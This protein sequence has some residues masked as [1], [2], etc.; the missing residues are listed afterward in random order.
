MELY[1]P[2]AKALQ[3]LVRDWHAHPETEL[4]ACFGPKGRVD[5]TTFL[6]IATRLKSKGFKPLPQIDRLSVLLPDQVRFQ[7][8]GFGIIQQYCR[9]DRMAGKPFVAMIKD[10]TVGTS[11]NLDLQEYDIR[12]KSRRELPL[13]KE[14]PKIQEL[15]NTWPLQKKAFRLIRRWSFEGAGVVYDLSMIRSSPQDVRGNYRFVRK[16]GDYDLIGSAPIYEV[17]VELKRGVGVGE[18]VGEGVGVGVGASDVALATKTLIAGLTTILRGIQKNILLCRKSVKTS[19]L[20]SYAEVADTDRFRGVAPITMETKNMQSLIDDATPN[21]RTGYNVTEKADGLRV[22][23]LCDKYGELY[24]IDMGMNVYRTG[25]VQPDCKS[26]LLD[27]E[28]VTRTKDNKAIQQLLI[29][30]IYVGPGKEN[31]TKLPFIA[32]TTADSRHKRLENWIALWKEAK[33]LPNTGLTPQTQIQV[34]MKKFVVASAGNDTIFRAAAQVLDTSYI[35]HTDGLIFTPNEAPLPQK[36]GTGFLS[37]FK[38]KPAEDNT[39]DFLVVTEKEP[40]T[41]KMDRI[42]TGIHP[43]SGETVSYKTLRLFVGSSKAAGEND[44]RTTILMEQPIGMVAKGNTYKPVLFNP[45]DNPDTMAT[46]CY[47]PVETDPDSGEQYIRAENSGEIIR[48]RSIVEMAYDPAR[49]PGWRWYAMRVRTDKTERLLKGILARTLNSEDVAESVWNSIHDPVTVSMIRTGSDEP[50]Q[51]EIAS[52]LKT[53]GDRAELSKKYYE[54]KAPAQ[55]LLRV[56]GLRD[57]HNRWIKDTLLYGPVLKP[58]GKTILD[59]AVGKAGDLQRWRRGRAGFVLGVDYAGENIRD[60]SNGAYR[61]L[62]DTIRNNG[63]AAVPPMF[64]AIGDSSKNLANGEAGATAEERDILRTILGKSPPEAALPP[65]V[66]KAGSGRLR[67]GADVMVCM[68]AIHYFFQDAKT[69]QGFLTNIQENLK[70]GGYFIGCAFDG[71]RVF[72]L[73]RGVPE[74]QSRVGTEDNTIL[75]TIT[76]RYS[77]EEIP[78]QDEGF[79]LPIDV[80]FI[81]IGS[82][83]KEYLVPF[84]LL[85]ERLR[86]IGVELVSAEGLREIGLKYSTAMFGD[87]Y[88]EAAKAGKVFP[89]GDAVKEFSSLN[90]WWVF[91]R[92]SDGGGESEADGVAEAAP[93]A[94]VAANEAYT[95]QQE[96]TQTQIQQQTQTQIQQQTQTQIQSQQATTRRRYKASEVINFYT[97]AGR[98]DKLGIKDPDYARYIAPSAY[99]ALPDPE[100]PSVIYPSLEHFLAG[101]KYKIATDN[102]KM[103]KLLFSTTGSIHYK[104]LNKRAEEKAMTSDRDAALLKDETNDIRKETTPQGFKRNKSTFNE[105]VWNEKQNELLKYAVETRYNKDPRFRK[106]LETARSQGKILVYYSPSGAASDLGGRRR[107]NDEMIEGGNKLGNIMMEVAGF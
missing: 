14:D 15:L 8:N 43:D 84:R 38:W 85:Q 51:T 91:K 1:P 89:M 93:V 83:H 33:L 76:K 37:Q 31:V 34:A 96:Q 29:F 48:D 102:P 3:A 86:S 105:V 87:S 88:K 69:F 46:V 98:Q 97:D 62:L 22:H 30:D 53:M 94:S 32:T 2:E 101:M 95:Q 92:V 5:V 56:R 107:A 71:E 66:E 75:W 7:L 57:F 27:G 9:D 12:I 61:R 11:S 36:P 60:P 35:Y 19:V 103:A 26:S 65:L 44:P 73:L 24:M 104:Y 16:F 6:S 99:F 90:R 47:I 63:P 64:F 42:Q 41:P 4:E 80:E 55:D 25:L 39:I 10:R 28:F 20:A 54:R 77:A 70:I 74:G 106:I 67:V 23:I 17:E 49:S 100:E 82:S 52:L 45:K 79:G 59:L 40:D 72:E 58:G 13:D 21:I 50:T 68:F 78:L 81:S 18:G